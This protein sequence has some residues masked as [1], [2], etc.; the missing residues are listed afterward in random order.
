MK[1]TRTDGTVKAILHTYACHN[2]TLDINQ[3]CG[4]YA[5]F[6]QAFL[7]QKLP[8]AVALFMAGCGADANPNP[9][10][11]L[12]LAQ[13]YGEELGAAVLAV[14]REPLREV[15][16]PIRAAYEEIPLA[17][18]TPPGREQIA[19]QLDS[20]N[21]YEQRRARR[22]LATL[23]Q[24]GALPATYPYP[25][26]VWRFGDG[27]EMP[28]LGGE[29]VVDY[30]LRLKEELGAGTWV[31]GYANDFMAYIPSLRVLREGGYEGGDAM[32]YFGHHG[33]WAPEIE[34]QIVQ[35]VHRLDANCRK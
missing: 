33:P 5:G 14:L 7:E 13:Q 17:F 15:H 34:E 28:V 27:L 22:L 35:A 11:R 12:E 26:E 2:T 25:V 6:S 29:V 9:R 16:G 23:D 30:S 32:V 8:G 24:E 19:R 20:S 3:F 18:S 4:D 1:I 31:V 21:V 10:R